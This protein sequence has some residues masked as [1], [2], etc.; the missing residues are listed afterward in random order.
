MAWEIE[1]TDQ[2]ARWYRELGDNQR[3]AI[4]AAI[5]VLA[6]HGP[7]TPRPTVAQVKGSRHH[8]LKELRPKDGN[9]RVLFLFDPRRSAILLVG[10]DKT[11]QWNAWYAE[12]IPVAEAL[13]DH[14]LDEL[15]NEGLID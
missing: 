10:G 7:A 4:S 2:F 11:G 5:D 3:A 14:Y 13:Y 9:V 8:N 15:R 1:G 6:E 12:M